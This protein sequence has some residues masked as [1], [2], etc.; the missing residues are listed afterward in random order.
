[1]ATT[2]ANADR[3]LGTF[4]PLSFLCHVDVIRKNL[5]TSYYILKKLTRLYLCLDRLWVLT[6]Y[7]SSIVT[8]STLRQLVSLTMVV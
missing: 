3:E 2:A 4:M 5:A 6:G 7:G 8:S 1:M